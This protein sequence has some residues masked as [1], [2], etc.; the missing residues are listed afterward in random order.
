MVTVAIGGAR[1]LERLR[2][3][4]P[5]AHPRHQKMVRELLY[6]AD[7]TD[8]M[9]RRRGRDHACL[10]GAVV[11]RLLSGA[12]RARQ[13]QELKA[14]DGVPVEILVGDSD[15]LTPEAAQ[16]PAR[17]GAARRD[18]QI[19]ERT[20][21]MLTQERP[22]LAVDGDRAAAGRRDRR[23]AAPDGAGDRLPAPEPARLR[24]TADDRRAQLVQIGLELLPTTPVQELT[25]DEV[26]RR[27]G[28]SRSLLFHYFATKR[29]YYTA[30]TRAA[31][32]LLWS[33]CSP[34]RHAAGE[35]V[36]GML[37]RYVGWVETYRETPP[38]V[39]ARGGAAA[40]RGCRRSTRRPATG[41]STW[42]WRP[43]TCPTTPLRRQLCS[44]GSP[45][46]RTS[47]V[48]WTREPRR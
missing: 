23:P 7:A 4:L 8:E 19:V 31:A 48:Q 9:V 2:Q 27:A 10:D 3:L 17:R 22:Q 26:A 45:S 11:R 1:A 5:P 30:V 39:R 41:W 14:L 15:K 40:T 32:D 38:G 37:D 21:H 24:R 6:G 42:R 13:A 43:W 20:G 44:P 28:I 35:Q 29:D 16:P 25:I 33:T 18:L 47:S 36:T 46:P 12:R 34:R